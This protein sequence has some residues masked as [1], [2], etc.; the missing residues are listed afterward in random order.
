MDVTISTAG[1]LIKEHNASLCSSHIHLS[2][3]SYDSYSMTT[4]SSD[5]QDAVA[6]HLE[7]VISL[8]P[9]DLSVS[10]GD[11]TGIYSHHI[12]FGLI[13]RGPV[14]ASTMRK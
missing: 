12:S 10:V 11:I 5:P 8:Y 2:I 3:C 4:A 1:I 13:T 6:T 9:L 7:A 14:S